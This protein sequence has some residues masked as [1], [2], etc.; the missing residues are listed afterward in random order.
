MDEIKHHLLQV[1]ITVEEIDA[2]W[3][4]IGYAAK[5]PKSPTITTFATHVDIMRR[6]KEIIMHGDDYHLYIDGFS[7]LP[8]VFHPVTDRGYTLDEVEAWGE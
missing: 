2:M 6:V 4:K 1:G 5:W 3:A 7:P 8:C